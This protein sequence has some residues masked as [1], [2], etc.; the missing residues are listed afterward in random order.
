MCCLDQGNTAEYFQKEKDLRDF[1]A[2]IAQR[3]IQNPVKHL[4]WTVLRK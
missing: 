2:F 1:N 3:Y 4:R